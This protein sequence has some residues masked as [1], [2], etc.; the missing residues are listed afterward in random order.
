M[1]DSP[2][3]N[4]DIKYQ[5]YIN[6]RNSLVTAQKESSQYFDKSILTLAAGALGLSLTF[7]DK[8]APRP[9]VECSKYLLCT[10]W[11]FFCLSILSTLIS[12]L[13]SQAACRRQIEIVENIFFNKVDT[14]SKNFLAQMTNVL[15]WISITLFVSGVF[16]LIIFTIINI[17]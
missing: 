15:N 4:E 17:K 7:I 13:T 11:I 10:A 6:E 16:F 8:I 3:E 14:N 2:N 1:P 12:S 9:I 5:T